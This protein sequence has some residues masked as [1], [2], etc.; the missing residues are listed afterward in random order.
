[1]KALK[2]EEPTGTDGEACAYIVNGRNNSD[3]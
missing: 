3:F 2:G 1:M